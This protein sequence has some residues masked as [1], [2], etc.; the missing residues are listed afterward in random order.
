MTDF[1]IVICVVYLFHNFIVF[2]CLLE[3]VFRWKCDVP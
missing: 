1:M 3:D 2:G